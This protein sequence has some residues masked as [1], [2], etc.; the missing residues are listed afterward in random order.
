MLLWC[1]IICC[2]NVDSS[3]FSPLQL[4]TMLDLILGA[5][6]VPPMTRC[7]SAMPKFIATI[8]LLVCFGLL[9]PRCADKDSVGYIMI[10]VVAVICA[11]IMLTRMFKAKKK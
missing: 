7:D 5:I 8:G 1:V 11:I 2:Q 10:L 6:I 4:V 9:I 3:G